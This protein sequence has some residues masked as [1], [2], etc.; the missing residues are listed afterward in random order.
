MLAQLLDGDPIRLE[1]ASVRLFSSELIDLVRTR[2]ARLVC[3][4]DLPPSLPSKTRYLVRKLNGALPEVAILVGRWA[5]AEM[6][7]EDRTIVIDAGATHVATTLLETRDQLRSLA[8]H[9]R[10]RSQSASSPATTAAG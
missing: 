6:A 7:D 9:E 5:P 3:I 4:A 1:V 10:Q 2:G 8:A